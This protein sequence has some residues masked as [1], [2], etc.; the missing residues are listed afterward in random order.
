M[1]LRDKDGQVMYVVRSSQGTFEVDPDDYLRNHQLGKLVNGPD[2]ILQMAHHVADDL[3]RQG[4]KDVKVYAQAM[5]SLNGREPQLLIDPEVDLAARSRSL[6][7]AD[8]IL[9]LEKPLPRAGARPGGQTGE[10]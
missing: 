5:A 7:P 4:H 2:L 9:P 6:L 10:E 8:W 1:K 3:R